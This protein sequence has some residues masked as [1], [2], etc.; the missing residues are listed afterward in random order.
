MYTKYQ[1]IWVVFS[2]LL[3]M[4]INSIWETGRITQTPLKINQYQIKL[5][6]AGKLSPINMIL[7]ER[8]TKVINKPIWE[9]K[10]FLKW[11]LPIYSKLTLNID[12]A[13]KCNCKQQTHFAWVP[14]SLTEKFHI[15]NL[16]SSPF[17]P[18]LSSIIA[19]PYSLTF[20]PIRFLFQLPFT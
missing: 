10:M 5:S 12:G 17:F 19:F 18:S 9:K 4:W 7:K 15:L 20:H 13:D 2:F 16:L 6:C 8:A 14:H 3:P 1:Q 11:F